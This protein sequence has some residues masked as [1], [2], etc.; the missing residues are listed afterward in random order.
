MHE[1]NLSDIKRKPK[2]NG[3]L[4]EISSAQEERMATAKKHVLNQSRNKTEAMFFWLMREG[5]HESGHTF[6]LK[7]RNR[8]QESESSRSP[9]GRR[10]T[11]Q[12]HF[13]SSRGHEGNDRASSTWLKR[14]ERQQWSDSLAR[15]ETNIRTQE[16]HVPRTIHLK[17]ILKK[18]QQAMGIGC[19]MYSIS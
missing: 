13:F 8:S 19:I 14:K 9:R 4:G 6:W 16:L 12:R 3:N 10:T 2:E 15:H 7:R 11:E 17:K 5:E 18:L 1:A